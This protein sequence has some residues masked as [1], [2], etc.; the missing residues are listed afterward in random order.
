[1]SRK[2]TLLMTAT[3][4]TAVHVANVLAEDGTPLSLVN[5]LRDEGI[6]VSKAAEIVGAW[7]QLSLVG[8]WKLLTDDGYRCWWAWLCLTF[9]LIVESREVDEL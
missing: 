7:R 4:H 9:D 3:D 6:L 1:M 5:S 2:P 8:R